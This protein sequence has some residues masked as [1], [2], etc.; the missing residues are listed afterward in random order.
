MKTQFFAFI[1]AVLC[2]FLCVVWPLGESLAQQS[3]ITEMSNIHCLPVSISEEIDLPDSLLISPESIVLRKGADTLNLAPVL[4]RG[5]ILSLKSI[6]EKLTGQKAEVCFRILPSY[7][8]K[9][10]FR[11][12][13][14][15]YDS[16]AYESE[17][18]RMAEAFRNAMNEN[19]VTGSEREEL[20]SSDLQKSGSLT[21]GISLGNTQDVFVNSALNLQLEGAIAQDLTLSALISDQNVPFQPEGNTQ[22]LQEFDRVLISL[23]HTQGRL[24]AGDVVFQRRNEG[25]FLRYYKNTTGAMLNVNLGSPDSKLS[26]STK[27]GISL[28]KGQFRSYFLEVREGVQ[29][30]YRLQGNN[31]EN[32]III[33]AGS[34]RVFLDNTP[35][36]R[37]YNLDYIIDY[38]TAEIT[39]NSNVLITAYSRVRVEFE[40]AVQNY[41]RTITALGHSQQI[42]KLHLYADFYRER[43]N[44]RQALFTELSD[45]QKQ[46]LSDVGDNIEA[47]FSESI[48]AV[49]TYNANRVLY[50]VEDALTGGVSRSFYRRAG[51]DDSPFFD[52]RFSDVGF[53]NGSYERINDASN[54][55]VYEWVGEGLGSYA[56]VELLA[57][58]SQ[59]QMAAFRTEYRF[60]ADER[61]SAEAAFSNRDLNLYSEKD[62]DDNRSAAFFGFYEIQDR[63]LKGR[64]LGKTKLSTR[65]S[66][67]LRQA[68]FSPVDR[69]R[70]VEFDRDWVANSAINSVDDHILNADINLSRNT[71]NSFHY[72]ASYRNKGKDVQGVQH[73]ADFRKELGFLRFRGNAF[74]MNNDKDSL[75]AE[76]QRLSGEVLWVQDY[77]Q[78]G[79]RFSTDRNRNTLKANDSVTTSAMFFD[80]HTFFLR[81]G[82]SSKLNFALDYILRDDYSP[83]NG[84]MTV[85]GRS[86]TF[87]GQAGGALGAHTLNLTA[88]Y[89]FWESLD[90]ALSD[91]EVIMG[92]FDWRGSFLKG[93]ISGELTY[94]NTT[95]QE[96]RREFYFQE[97]NT[98]QGTHTWRDD[99]ADGIQDLGEFYLAVNP[100]ERRFIKIWIPGTE[101]VTAFSQ[102]H[103]FRLNIQPPRSWKKAKAL[104]GLLG[105]FAGVF[106]WQ[107]RQRTTA[108]AWNERFLPLA[109]FRESENMLFKQSGLRGV[110]FFNRG[111]QH[112]GASLEAEQNE[113]KSL[114]NNGFEEQGSSGLSLNTRF[115][116]SADLIFRLEPAIRERFNASDF[117]ENR[118][119]SLQI[120][121]LTSEVTWQ[122]G[123]KWRLGLLYRISEKENNAGTENALVQE[124]KLKGRTGSS[125]ERSINGEISR[126]QMNFNGEENTPVAYEMLEALASG[127]NWR[128]NLNVEQR[129]ANGLRL[130]FIYEG[131]TSPRSPLIHIGRVQVTA[132]F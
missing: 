41:N 64:L 49:E 9:S 80:E 117:L 103:A 115:T 2:T 110:L 31:N 114:L 24:D 74:L 21:R 40:Y 90:T 131:R 87:T 109:A 14:A 56:P 84:E 89:R 75:Q 26:T 113:G 92:R 60:R 77:I 106:S 82:D 50:T 46:R 63:K 86:N 105:R 79:Y 119:Y 93:I 47:A 51:P 88:T 98:G 8:G 99:N 45:A 12:S 123:Q 28:A 22:Q 129:L 108:T 5:N 43:D 111:S 126:L 27:A 116:P 118:N 121:E 96:P 54:G 53:G 58:P 91:R 11:R 102:D 73:E 29:G 10:F 37:G 55:R 36:K 32:F 81:P 71:Y 69:Y 127:A 20:F 67:E 66:Y 62:A 125:G 95:G 94:N 112:F 39:F 13:Q 4:L 100:D 70:S 1:G 132:L 130:S 33:L 6:P 85:E 35:L 97:I 18:V 3:S 124:I 76:W 83:K 128:W 120:R 52:I 65:L 7:L 16:G 68:D 61:I 25:R 72:S 15:L 23:K 122:P 48:E 19:G 107:H 104:K 38:N 44:P 57:A 78:P 59:K 42:G 17:Q 101:F 30:P 34:E